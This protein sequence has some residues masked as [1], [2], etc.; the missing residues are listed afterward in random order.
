MQHTDHARAAHGQRPPIFIVA[1]MACSH[2]GD[3]RLARAIIDAAGAAGAD[4]IQFQMWRL[5]DMVTPDHPDIELLRRLEMPW[6]Q[7]GELAAYA[8]SR[9]PGLEIV[10][11]VYE[12]FTVD[13]AQT[14]NVDAYK[15]HSSDLSNPTLVRRLARTG[16]PVHLSVGASSL[17]EIQAAL[18]W[19]REEGCRDITLMFGYQNFPTRIDD[20]HLDYLPKL[21]GLFELPVGYQDHT[22]AEHPGAFHLPAAA[23]GLGVDILEK[24][25]THDRSLKGVDHQ[26]ALNPD[27]FARF[28]RM[29]RDIELGRGIGVPK[30]WSEEERHYRAIA[31]KSIVL[32]RDAAAGETLA[33]GD[34]LFLRAS[35]PGLPPTCAGRL[36]GKRLL[37]ALPAW[38]VLAEEDVA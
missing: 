10:A 5:A 15:L 32:G 38:T 16:R 17:D 22:D 18:E 12:P 11:C 25:I 19:A 26:A 21:R 33:E 30:P 37:R 9:H 13:F 34:L 6:A 27:E 2:E 23:A 1:E 7:W 28:V 29:V 20:A 31:K 14:I 35:R 24:H 36:V 4:A 3:P 8:R